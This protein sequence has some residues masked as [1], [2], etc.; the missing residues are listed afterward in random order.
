MTGA[1]SDP[2][3]LAEYTTQHAHSQKGSNILAALG[4]SRPTHHAPKSGNVR[5]VSNEPKTVSTMADASAAASGM[6]ANG[7]TFDFV[8][9]SM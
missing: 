7:A 1:V 5:L 3:R 9:V 8:E 2:S 6:T 4:Q